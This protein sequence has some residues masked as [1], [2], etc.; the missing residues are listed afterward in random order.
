MTEFR[1]VLIRVWN[2]IQSTLDEVRSLEPNLRRSFIVFGGNRIN[3]IGES[4]K[5]VVAKREF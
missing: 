2:P 5:R 3:K 1:G 4:V